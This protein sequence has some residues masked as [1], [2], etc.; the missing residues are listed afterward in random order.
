MGS[1][2]PARKGQGCVLP[3]RCAASAVVILPWQ[4]PRCTPLEEHAVPGLEGYAVPGHLVPLSSYGG[5]QGQVLGL[6]RPP[7]PPAASIAALA[8]QPRWSRLRECSPFPSLVCGPDLRLK[9]LK[10][11][12]SYY[13]HYFIIFIILLFSF[14][15]YCLH[16][17]IIL[18]S[19][20]N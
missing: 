7:R 11:E 15:S 12:L 17:H 13:L 4:S 6:D 20:L 19:S 8:W 5:R 16:S 2:G 9:G 10:H 18:L 1:S 14:S 3:L